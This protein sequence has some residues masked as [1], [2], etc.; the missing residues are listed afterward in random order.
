M[1]ENL[2]SKWKIFV[3]KSDFFKI[4]LG[5]NLTRCLLLIT[6]YIFEYC[7]EY[8]NPN[9]IITYPL[10][11]KNYGKSFSLI[12]NSL[13][14]DLRTWTVT[15]KVYDFFEINFSWWKIL[16]KF[17]IFHKSYWISYLN[18]H[19]FYLHN[20]LLLYKPLYFPAHERDTV[21]NILNIYCIQ[22]RLNLCIWIKLLFNVRLVSMMRV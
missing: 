14:Q 12:L 13:L 2:R 6:T 20:F 4:I 3:P 16:I 10:Q 22:K 1:T 8:H 15:W 5:Q 19:I 17:L 11:I 18:F 21:F 9:S 7:I